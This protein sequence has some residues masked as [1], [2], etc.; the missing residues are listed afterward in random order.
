MEFGEDYCLKSFM[1]CDCDIFDIVAY[2]EK[3]YK[4][5]YLFMKLLL[6]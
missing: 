2:M 6:F 3:V 5:L 1:L 4:A